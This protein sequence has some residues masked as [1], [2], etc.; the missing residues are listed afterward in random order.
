MQHHPGGNL[1]V[2]SSPYGPDPG[3]DAPLEAGLPSDLRKPADG[4]GGRLPSLPGRLLPSEKE[5]EKRR[6]RLALCGSLPLQIRLWAKGGGQGK[7]IQ[8][9]LGIFLEE[10]GGLG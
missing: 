7:G 8:A 1:G 10:K 6:R 5:E 4:E 3:P 2:L 9:H